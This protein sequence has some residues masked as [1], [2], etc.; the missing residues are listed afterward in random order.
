[1]A[2]RPAAD[3]LSSPRPRVPAR[4]LQRWLR[5]RD[6]GSWALRR[7]ARAAIV[8]PALF[9]FGIKILHNPQLATFAAFGSFAL[10]LADLRGTRRERLEAT[11]LLAV[12]GAGFVA[13]GTLVSRT[14]WR[15]ALSMAVVGFAVLFSGW[16]ARWRPP[17]RPASDRVRPPGRHSGPRRHAAGPAGRV[18]AGPGRRRRRGGRALA[19]ARS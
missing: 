1:M 17:P 16:S 7:A 13:L 11:A 2:R 6:P 10:L 15:A 5:R 9:A 19:R 14:P 18:G 4:A 12:T 3:C 8:M